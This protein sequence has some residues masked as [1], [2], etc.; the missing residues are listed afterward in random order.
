MLGQF[1]CA[2]YFI[3]QLLHYPCLLQGRI[4]GLRC[5][6]DWSFKSY[7]RSM[8]SSTPH[9]HV[10]T[11]LLPSSPMYWTSF[12]TVKL[13]SSCSDQNST[14][15]LSSTFNRFACW[16]DARWFWFVLFILQT[17]WWIVTGSN[18]GAYSGFLRLPKYMHWM[19]WITFLNLWFYS[20]WSF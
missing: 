2:T 12:F 9:M 19:E 6:T 17:C 5:S 10:S 8:R 16:E 18:N 1:D 13:S 15:H 14:T 3:C 7:G 20:R 11:F 4:R